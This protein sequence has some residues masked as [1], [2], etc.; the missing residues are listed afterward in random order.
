MNKLQPFLPV[1]LG[2]LIF[3]LI[4]K[5]ALYQKLDTIFHD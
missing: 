3:I 5:Q 2:F 4:P 1:I